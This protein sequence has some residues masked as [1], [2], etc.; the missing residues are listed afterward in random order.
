[1]DKCLL[2]RPFVA[3][4]LVRINNLHHMVKHERVAP[5]KGFGVNYM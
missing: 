2:P 3:E 5:G 4:N 1:M